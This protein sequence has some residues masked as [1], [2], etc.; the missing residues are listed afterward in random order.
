MKTK[1]IGRSTSEKIEVRSCSI[2]C[3]N[4]PE[5]GTWGVMED[6]GSFFEIYGRAGGR[7]LN[8]DEADRF[9]HVI[10]KNS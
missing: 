9:W 4:H 10:E 5:W 8:K 6:K 3:L 2:I 7:V 1:I